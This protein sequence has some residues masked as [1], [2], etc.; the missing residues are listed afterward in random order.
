MFD[1]MLFN[2]VVEDNFLFVGKKCKILF[3]MFYGVNN[4]NI[5]CK[6]LVFVFYVDLYFNKIFVKIMVLK[7]LK[8]LFCIEEWWL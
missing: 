8:L 6:K 3:L 1:S 4:L 7:N 2:F 5:V